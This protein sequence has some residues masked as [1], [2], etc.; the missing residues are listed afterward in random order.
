MPVILTHAAN[1]FSLGTIFTP[2]D[3][4]TTEDM[5]SFL[6]D[7]FP[8]LD[9]SSLSKIETLH[10]KSTQFPN[11][12]EFFSAAALA[13]GELQYTCPGIFISGEI[14]DFSSPNPIG[15]VSKLWIICYIPVKRAE[16]C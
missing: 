15:F 10:P 11:Y 3:F 13:Y 7:N 4:N 6:L 16:I 14:R 1:S 2:N 8:N 5:N 9:S 12:T